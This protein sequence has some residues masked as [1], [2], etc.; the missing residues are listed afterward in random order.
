MSVF[1]QLPVDVGPGD[2]LF[3][4]CDCLYQKFKKGLP[5]D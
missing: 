5:I 4:Q 3:K 2:R 1:L